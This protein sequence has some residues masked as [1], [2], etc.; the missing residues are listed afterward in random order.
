MKIVPIPLKQTRGSSKLSRWPTL[1]FSSSCASGSS[2][3]S[4]PHHI[5]NRL[6]ASQ[7]LH[8]GRASGRVLRVLQDAAG[9]YYHPAKSRQLQRRYPWRRKEN[10]RNFQAARFPAGQRRRAAG[11]GGHEGVHASRGVHGHDTRWSFHRTAPR[12]LPWQRPEGRRCAP[13]RLQG[14][15]RGDPLEN[16]ATLRQR[17]LQVELALSRWW[18]M[19]PL[20]RCK[21]LADSLKVGKD[22]SPCHSAGCLRIDLQLFMFFSHACSSFPTDRCY[23]TVTRDSVSI[24]YRICVNLD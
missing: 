18:E 11:E 8:E 6:P 1:T 10:S 9:P 22:W 2:P 5:V 21:V 17:A 23:I 7:P 12:A 19:V 14:G 15:W 4:F 3:P 20:L 16:S 13:V 24:I